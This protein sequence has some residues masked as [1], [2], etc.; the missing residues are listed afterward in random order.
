MI[1]REHR[2]DGKRIGIDLPGP[3]IG[4]CSMRARM[5]VR[6]DAQRAT[7]S[8]H[9][10]LVSTCIVT[11]ALYITH[12]FRDALGGPVVRTRVHE[13]VGEYRVGQPRIRASASVPCKP[14]HASAGWSVSPCPPLAKSSGLVM[15]LTD[16]GPSGKFKVLSSPCYSP[17]R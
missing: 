9:P 13:D 10:I 1:R 3:T 7:T 2:G 8:T 11:R 6:P 15:Y 16:L 4:T 17:M 12:V 14:K 5:R